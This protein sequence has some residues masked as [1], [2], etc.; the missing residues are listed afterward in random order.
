MLSNYNTL[1]IKELYCECNFHYIEAHRNIG[2]SAI[3]RG[4]VEDVIITNYVN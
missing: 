4:A 1:F 3:N 2:A